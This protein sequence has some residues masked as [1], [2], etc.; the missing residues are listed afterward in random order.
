MRQ[1]RA[2]WVVVAAV[3]LLLLLVPPLRQQTIMQMR[4]IGSCILSLRHATIGEILLP[5]PWLKAVDQDLWDTPEGARMHMRRHV[6]E[7][8]ATA[9]YMVAS[10]RAQAYARRRGASDVGVL[11]A[12]Y[13][14]SD[15]R[16]NPSVLREAAEAAGAPALWAAYTWAMF[17][18]LERH[19]TVYRRVEMEG[20]D[21]A[22][23]AELAEMHRKYAEDGGPQSLT[24][25]QARPFLN[26]LAGWRKADPE[27][28]FPVALE[29]WV[30]YG[31]HRDR[32]ALERWQH[33]A[34]CAVID[35]RIKEVDRE[36][37][38]FG[39]RIGIAEP[40]ASFLGMGGDSDLFDLL[41]LCAHV[42][43][44]EGR[45]AQIGGR[46]KEAIALWNATVTIGRKLEE[47]EFW[48]GLS[49]QRIGMEP[50]WQWYPPDRRHGRAMY[51]PQHAFYVSQVGPEV[52]V[53]LRD[54][55]VLSTVRGRLLAQETQGLAGPLVRLAP[56]TV[57]MEAGGL[58]GLQAAL[59]LFLHLVWFRRPDRSAE[60]A[61]RLKPPWV[62]VMAALVT[63]PTPALLTVVAFRAP[64]T[65]AFDIGINPGRAVLPA[66]VL[67]LLALL[68]ATRR[69]NASTRV[70]QVWRQI[71]SQ[72]V[73]LAAALL[74]LSFLVTAL[75]A[76]PIRAGLTRDLRA[77]DWSE[78]KLYTNRLG[79][80]WSNP[81]IPPDS[82]RA[83][84]PPSMPSK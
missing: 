5:L 57:L 71:M 13:D 68:A 30:L 9:F 61:H 78:M 64:E 74:A 3:L 54:A 34:S 84:Y 27:N 32:E 80:S 65:I 46:P 25:E 2:S 63:L 29:A 8:W 51:G 1:I 60:P 23:Q 82:W 22:D 77:A 47:R 59:L 75:I 31:L 76:L 66:L 24:P 36:A 70:R 56:V 15:T 55:L 33:A 14:L 45:Q 40:E 39:E 6:G 10:D 58:V 49:L 50:A 72:T 28:G 73:P 21:P 16:V 62:L 42:A 48:R 26:A 79:P 69:R 4:V 44:F 19:D 41:W 81:T 18:D 17:F 53:A 43:E 67:A 20:L 83:E 52:D 11:L 37:R 38:R 35:P 7:G 12:A